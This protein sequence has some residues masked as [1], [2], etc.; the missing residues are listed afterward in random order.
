MTHARKEL[1]CVTLKR[2]CGVVVVVCVCGGKVRDVYVSLFLSGG[3]RVFCGPTCR[4]ACLRRVPSA[5]RTHV[6][7]MRNIPLHTTHFRE[8]DCQYT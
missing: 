3:V 4:G 2:E 6:S 1:T 8:L 7:A 5:V